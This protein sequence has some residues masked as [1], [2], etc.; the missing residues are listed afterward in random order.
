MLEM[1]RG[2]WLRIKEASVFTALSMQGRGGKMGSVSCSQSVHRA[3]RQRA[4]TGTKWLH[5]HRRQTFVC[6]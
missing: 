1:G 4:C 2:W 6:E 5:L 3:I